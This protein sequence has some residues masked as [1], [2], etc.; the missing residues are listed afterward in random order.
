LETSQYSASHA[1][2]ETV[3]ASLDGVLGGFG[4]LSDIDV[5]SSR[6]LLLETLQ[7]LHP[8]SPKQM[9]AL[10]C[11]AGIGRVSKQLL[12]PLFGTV[13]LVESQP[14]FLK[15]AA[16]LLSS[17]AAYGEAFCSPLQTFDLPRQ[18]YHVIWVQWVLGYLTDDDVVSFLRRCQKALLP[19]GLLYIKENVLVDDHVATVADHYDPSVT[20]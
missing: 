13:D 2:W 5:D 15:R 11:G 4:Y 10:D 16:Q 7:H 18:R 1:Y 19:R 3:D 14:K 20:R 17:E 8:L 9:Y 6:K 12:M